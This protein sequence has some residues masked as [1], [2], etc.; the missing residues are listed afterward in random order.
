MVAALRG[1]NGDAARRCEQVAA[2]TDAAVVAQLLCARVA[3]LED[4]PEESGV[5]PL[6]KAMMQELWLALGQLEF[7]GK[8]GGEEKVA[9]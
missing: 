9:G 6:E 8:D 4:V 3:G 5:A 7:P 1:E 2:A